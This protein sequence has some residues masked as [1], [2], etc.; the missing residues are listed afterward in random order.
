MLERAELL[1]DPGNGSMTQSSSVQAWPKGRGMGT[2]D[3]GAAV[4]EVALGWS[5]SRA[6]GSGAKANC[7]R[8]RR[9]RRREEAA[10]ETLF[11][12]SDIEQKWIHE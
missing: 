4:T 10:R 5:P 9:R 1:R 7:N 3:A 11:K 6:Q 2:A 8:G 12:K